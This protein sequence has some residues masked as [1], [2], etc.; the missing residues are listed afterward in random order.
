MS[1]F[2]DQAAAKFAELGIDINA[3]SDATGIGNSGI[4]GTDEDWEGEEEDDEEDDLGSENIMQ[5]PYQLGFPEE[6]VNLLHSDSNWRNW[7]GGRIGGK[8]V[9]LNPAKAPSPSTLQCSSCLEPLQFVLQIY[10]PLDDITSAFHRSLYVFACRHARCIETNASSVKCIRSQLSRQN[11]YYA[12]SP[13][14]DARDGHEISATSSAPVSTA[15]GPAFT[16]A[17]L[18]EVCGCG[19][20]FSC[21]A[22]SA[23]SYCS[24]SHQRKHWKL[25][26]AICTGHA[27]S[28]AAASA[29]N[30]DSLEMEME[31]S[32]AM[33]PADSS[34]SLYAEYDLVV[35]PEELVKDNAASKESS[36]TIW[37]DAHTKGGADEAE[38]LQLQQSDYDKALGNKSRDAEYVSFLARIRRGGPDQ[39][40]RYARWEADTG[41]LLISAAAAELSNEAKYPV[42]VCEYCRAPRRFEFQVMPQLLH[43]L[44]V[45]LDTQVINPDAQ[46]ARFRVGTGQAPDVP[47]SEAIRNSRDYDIDW[48]TL[49]VFTCTASCDASASTADGY[50]TEYVRVVAGHKLT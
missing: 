7:D 36:A 33:I 25:H 8:P 37:E 38:D 42:P 20:P 46:D 12:H 18:C 10:C 28:A 16:P 26:K 3:P 6:G 15:A 31:A 5:T 48:G 24:R 29:S 13:P 22:C 2:T 45:D 4:T 11:A 39:V 44:K 34:H 30:G 40:L 43:F 35:S 21:K 19:A 9:W 23:A 17:A 41:P 1:N 32:E 49:D 50:A 47:I 14:E 27:G